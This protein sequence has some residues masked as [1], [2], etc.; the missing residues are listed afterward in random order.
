MT[1]GYV[2]T[3]ALQC[4]REEMPYLFPQ[5]Q[6]GASEKEFVEETIA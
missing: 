4:P 3:D 1:L 6:Q 5:L 2:R